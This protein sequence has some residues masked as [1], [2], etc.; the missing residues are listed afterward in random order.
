MHLEIL[1][2]DSS[3]R[4]LLEAVVPK[5]LGPHAEPHTWK[6]IG[7]KGLGHLPRGLKSSSDPAKRILLDRLPNIL[8]A[9]GKS[10]WIDG[11]LVLVD[12]DRRDCKSFLD[13]LND[14]VAQMSPAPCVVFRL[15]IEE[16]EAW[17]FGDRAALL[18]AYP[19]ARREILDRYAQ[20]SVC[21]TW[22]LLAD[23]I[24]PGGSAQI[25]TVGYPFAGQI[26][27]AWAERI[28]PLMNPQDNASPSFRKFKDALVRLTTPT[29]ARL[30]EQHDDR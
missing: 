30:P 29:P 6:V 21:S 22:E 1:V 24:H 10:S 11:V 13:E 14:I 3:G 5:I 2:E 15:A 8:R 7:Y 19:R 12:A 17:Y 26:K 25:M 4:C 23:A 28:G 20:D 16:V 27:H 18:S 9:Y